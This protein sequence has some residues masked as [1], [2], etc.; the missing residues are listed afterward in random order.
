MT[1]Q[2][3][4]ALGSN[5]DN[6]TQ[7][8]LQAI[9]RIAQFPETVLIQTSSLYRTRPMGY[10]AQD[11]FVN[12][13]VCIATQ[14][15]PEELLAHVQ[16]VEQAQRRVREFDNGPRTIDCDILLFGRRVIDTPT[17]QVP[18][19]GLTSRDF[20]LLPLLEISPECTL[21]NGQ[22]LQLAFE[23]LTVRYC[24]TDDVEEAL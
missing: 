6:P 15:C 16:A 9:E 5:L 23:A 12:A 7:Q 4:I 10:A 20:V 22:S 8:V 18:H 3:F 13:V 19:P 11:D 24:V 14:L 17:L 21:P 2:V 1:E